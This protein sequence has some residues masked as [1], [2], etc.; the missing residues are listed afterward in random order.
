MIM[1]S[2]GCVATCSTK[3]GKKRKIRDE[4]RKKRKENKNK[5]KKD[6]KIKTKA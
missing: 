3:E 6:R 4:Y 1:W 2:F 5:K